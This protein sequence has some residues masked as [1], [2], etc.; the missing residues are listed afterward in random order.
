MTENI[1]KQEK[2]FAIF[3]HLGAFAGYL[4]PFGNI[5]APLIIWL[6]KKNEMPFV[7]DQGKESLNF[8]ISIT[9]Y[10]LIAALL[11]LIAIGFI[12]IIALAIFDIVM[13]IIATVKANN[14][15]KYRYPLT[16]RFIK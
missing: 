1:D 8:Q 16:I 2:T 4:L 11:T 14:G 7:D 10:F 3:C 5:L 13:V 9:I 6:V 12:V 15:E